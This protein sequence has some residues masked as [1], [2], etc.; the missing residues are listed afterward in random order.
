MYNTNFR[1]V[2]V[3]LVVVCSLFEVE[4]DDNDGNYNN[5]FELIVCQSDFEDGTLIID[6]PNTL[7]TLSCDI[8][9][10]PKSDW[11]I[12]PNEE[13]AYICE[14]IDADIYQGCDKTS[15]SFRLG[16]FSAISIKADNVTLDLNGHT[17]SVHEEFLLQQRFFALIGVG[18]A[19][20]ISGQG[21]ANFG[22]TDINITNIKIHNGVL[23][24]SPHHGIHGNLVN[25]IE[26][27]N[28]KIFDFEVAGIQ[29]NGFENA[30]L[31]DIEIGASLTHVPV[32]G[33]YS[34]ARFGL[35]SF[36]EIKERLEGQLSA[37]EL[38]NN[39]V[40]NFF[41]VGKDGSKG[42]LN[43]VEIV[44]RLIEGMD[45]YFDYKI[46]GIIPNHDDDK[47]SRQ[48]WREALNEFDNNVGGLPDGSALYGILLN[49][50]GAAVDWFGAST[51]SM[52]ENAVLENIIIKDLNLK[53]N[54]VIG[55]VNSA[56]SVVTGLFVLCLVTPFCA[57]LRWCPVFLF[58]LSF[59]FSFL[60]FSFFFFRSI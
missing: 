10:N 19:P 36:R 13:G 11:I 3:F 8:T 2:F 9:F 53:V 39:Y 33:K 60:F 58:C 20:F 49:S 42:N 50:A 59:L 32:V 45:L 41:N 38:N 27:Y 40:V 23:G 55:Y 47:N 44:E 51:S 22:E 25:N 46:N 17:L 15:G 30:Y 52:S 5:Y 21:P 29:L 54:E 26:I 34:Q 4:C 48:L 16:F 56:G 18:Q 31:H 6:E 43:V 1:A 28:L 57:N 14:S 7:I 24:L 35:L 12:S 37:S